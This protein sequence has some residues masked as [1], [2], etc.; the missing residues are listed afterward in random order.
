MGQTTDTAAEAVLLE[1]ITNGAADVAA[2]RAELEI[3]EADGR[4][5]ASLCDSARELI[6]GLAKL[7]HE[8][9]NAPVEGFLTD[10]MAPVIGAGIK[11]ELATGPAQAAARYLGGVTGSSPS[12]FDDCIARPRFGR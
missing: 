4:E 1:I 3:A 5:A 11:A 6:A 2:A 10:L 12:A 9:S 8:Q 7:A